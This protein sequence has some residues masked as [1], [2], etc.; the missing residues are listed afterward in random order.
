[1]CLN[2]VSDYDTGFSVPVSKLV[3]ADY[4]YFLVRSINSVLLQL[5]AAARAII[6]EEGI[7]IRIQVLSVKG[8]KQGI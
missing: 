5:T 4:L 7:R 2:K 1:M 3:N 8:M 6:E